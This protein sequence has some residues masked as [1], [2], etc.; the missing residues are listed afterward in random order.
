MKRILGVFLLLVTFSTASAQTSAVTTAALQ[1]QQTEYNFGKVPQGKPVYY[2]FTIVNKSNQALKL[3]NVTADCGCT[4]PEWNKAAIAPGSSTQI[5]VGFNAAQEGPFEKSITVHYNGD[6]T[7]QLKIK[8]T[9]WVAPSG[10]PAN[11][12]VQFLKQQTQ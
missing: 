8:G 2:T 11:N 9:V 10:A 12:V 7:T 6:K 1:P 4:T 5:K 3:D